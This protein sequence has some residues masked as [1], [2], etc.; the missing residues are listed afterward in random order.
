VGVRVSLHF[1]HSRLLSKI[2][3]S[4]KRSSK[5]NL[6]EWGNRQGLSFPIN[7]YC[8]SVLYERRE[9]TVKEATKTIIKLA[10]KSDDQVDSRF[11]EFITTALDG[12]LP[13]SNY[14]H[15]N[16]THEPLLLKMNDAAKKLGVSRVTFW[17]L[18]S[19]QA[20]KPIEIFEGVFR[21]NYS[22]LI[23]FSQQRSLY[24]P[25]SRGMTSADA[26]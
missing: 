10:I 3:P 12:S 11:A 17:R 6:S 20:I 7:R 19:T 14:W 5:P 15:A 2:L 23:N 13:E 24:K 25:K 9:N 22:D 4:L 21:Y 16:S 26:R 1:T 18:V 8:F